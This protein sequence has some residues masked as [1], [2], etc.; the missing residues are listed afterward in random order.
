VKGWEAHSGGSAS[1]SK[2]GAL[3]SIPHDSKE[4]KVINYKPNRNVLN[5]FLTLILDEKLNNIYSVIFHTVTHNLFMT[6]S[7]KSIE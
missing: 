7:V 1:L 2:Y 3:R 6:A 4:R 5:S